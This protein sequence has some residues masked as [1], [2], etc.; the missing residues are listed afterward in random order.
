MQALPIR[1]IPRSIDVGAVAQTVASSQY[2]GDN[3]VC[4]MGRT[5]EGITLNHSSCFD[6]IVERFYR[7]GRKKACPWHEILGFEPFLMRQILSYF[8]H[9]KSAISQ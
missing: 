3:N 8:S 4:S 7:S 1:C 5:A 9:L 2:R 6:F